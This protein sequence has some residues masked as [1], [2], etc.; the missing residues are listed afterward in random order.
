MLSALPDA[1]CVFDAQ[2]RLAYAN[3]AGRSFWSLGEDEY[4]GRML[5][6]LGRHA[7]LAVVLDRE[8]ERALAIASKGREGKRAGAVVPNGSQD[9]VAF[10]FAP[11]ETDA[12]APRL[13]LAWLR[14]LASTDPVRAD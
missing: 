5:S 9:G 8:L 12:S 7:S 14:E 10:G 2:R 13:M 4:V 11:V 6:E 3:A 1:V